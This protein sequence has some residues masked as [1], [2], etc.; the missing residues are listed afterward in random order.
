MNNDFDEVDSMVEGDARK[1]QH[2]CPVC[3]RPVYYGITCSNYCADKAYRQWKTEQA[4]RHE[5]ES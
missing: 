5:E 3:G 4:H 1:K 2:T